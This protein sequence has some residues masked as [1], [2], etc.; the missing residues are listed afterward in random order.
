MKTL[1]FDKDGKSTP[2]DTVQNDAI[3]AEVVSH[4]LPEQF[5]WLLAYTRLDAVWEALEDAARDIN[6]EAYAMLKEQ[7]AKKKFHLSRTLAL[8]SQFE[9]QAKLLV[10]NADLSEEAITIA[11]NKAL[12]ADI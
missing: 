5:E 7:R 9:E 1:T 3:P 10:P 8:I 4:L 6:L 12:V 11:W 2:I